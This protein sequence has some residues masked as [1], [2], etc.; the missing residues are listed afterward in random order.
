METKQNET[1]TNPSFLK[2]I[3]LYN[4]SQNILLVLLQKIVLNPHIW[5][6]YI[7]LKFYANISSPLF[8]STD[9]SRVN[10]YTY[11]SK[12]LI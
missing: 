6:I 2:I 10:K 3:L 4:Y 9:I 5:N 7:P 11:Y 12:D 1:I 8:Q